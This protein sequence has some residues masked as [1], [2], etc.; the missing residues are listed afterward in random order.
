MDF[1]I[2][3][4]IEPPPDLCERKVFT[5]E[6]TNQSQPVERIACVT[7][8]RTSAFRRP[9]Q[10]LLDVV[11]NRSLADAS[12]FGEFGEVEGVSVHT[13]IVTVNMLTVNTRLLARLTLIGRTGSRPL[14]GY[15]SR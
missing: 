13:S 5:L 7:S 15:P 8:P 10:S 9:D 11:A 6:S 4:T 2:S 3:K 12:Q 1:H 14:G